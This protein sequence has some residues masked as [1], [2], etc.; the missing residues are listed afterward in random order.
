MNKYEVKINDKIAKVEKLNAIEQR[1]FTYFNSSEKYSENDKPSI[2]SL[3]SLNKKFSEWDKIKNAGTFKIG[4]TVTDNNIVKVTRY[5]LSNSYEYANFYIPILTLNGDGS[6]VVDYKPI[7]SISVT[8][9]DKT[10]RHFNYEN[11]VKMI[12]DTCNKNC[13]NIDK[14]CTDIKN[15][16][17]E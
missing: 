1:L 4:Q 17:A 5:I 13:I 9:K 7:N 2:D 10:E 11:F 14:F 15:Y 8:I 12:V 3:K 16:V 6:K